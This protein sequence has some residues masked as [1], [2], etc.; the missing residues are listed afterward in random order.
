MITDKLIKSEML[1][2]EFVATVSNAIRRLE[3]GDT[4]E[5]L[6]ILMEVQ[7]S[8]QVVLAIGELY[9]QEYGPTKVH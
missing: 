2:E 7:I 8:M 1:A 9:D 5:C 6:S 4:K 3:N